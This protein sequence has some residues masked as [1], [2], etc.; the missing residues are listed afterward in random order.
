MTAI[1]IM[2][3]KPS[4][5][6]S[7]AFLEYTYPRRRSILSPEAVAEGGG[8]E[9][10]HFQVEPGA[11][12]TFKAAIGDISDGAIDSSCGADSAPDML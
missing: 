4:V 8:I 9:P 5:V 6:V 10:A 7:T 12:D 3:R 2:P 1:L 11:I